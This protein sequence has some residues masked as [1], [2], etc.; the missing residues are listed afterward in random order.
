[1][2]IE[3]TQVEPDKKLKGFIQILIWKMYFWKAEKIFK[4]YD[5]KAAFSRWVGTLLCFTENIT[6]LINDL[7][8]FLRSGFNKKYEFRLLFKKN[9]TF[10]F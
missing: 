10:Q 8:N 1:M 2:T 4:V 6:L 3:F 9:F 7:I 5:K